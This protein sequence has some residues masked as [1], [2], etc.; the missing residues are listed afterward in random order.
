MLN[1][2]E[3]T[4]INVSSPKIDQVAEA[5]AAAVAEK[6]QQKA[7][8]L[9]QKERE[10]Q[11]IATGQTTYQFN[12]P[13]SQIGS[14]KD[15][16]EQVSPTVWRNRDGTF[17][18]KSQQGGTFNVDTEEGLK[19]AMRYDAASVKDQ[20]KFEAGGIA[21]TAVGTAETAVN[22][23]IDIGKQF[24]YSGA[25]GLE[26]YLNSYNMKNNDTAG[27]EFYDPTRNALDA[28]KVSQQYQQVLDTQKRS[29]PLTPEQVEFLAS[30][31]GKIAAEGYKEV[32]SNIK[33]L[34]AFD[35]AKVD[36]SAKRDGVLMDMGY[37]DAKERGG[38][39]EAIKYALNDPGYWAKAGVQSIPYMVALTAGGPVT[40]TLLVTSLARAKAA[41][42]TQEFWKENK[43]G[44]TAEEQ[45]Y[46]DAYS[47][48]STTAEKYADKFLLGQL[49]I[50]NK[51]LGNLTDLLPTS[52]QWLGG[53]G[54]GLAGEGASGAITETLDQLAVSREITDPTAIEFAAISEAFASPTGAAGVVVASSVTDSVIEQAKKERFTTGNIDS[55]IA[56]NNTALDKVAPAL[57]E[58][59]TTALQSQLEADKAEIESLKDQPS[60]KQRVDN[61]TRR[62]EQ[63][64]AKINTGRD[65]KFGANSSEVASEIQ[66]LLVR[67]RILEERKKNLNEPGLRAKLSNV[68][69]R[70]AD[71]VRPE[72]QQTE[73]V[74]TAVDSAAE[75]VP[76]STQGTPGPEASVVVDPKQE[77][78][79]PFI[80]A[81]SLVERLATL[82][83]GSTEAENLL[84]DI[85][86]HLNIA[87]NYAFGTEIAE[88]AKRPAI[89]RITAIANKV[90]E[91]AA[92]E[93]VDTKPEEDGFLNLSTP[94]DN[95][96]TDTKNSLDPDEVVQ[97][98]S[99][100]ESAA[101][102]QAYLSSINEGAQETGQDATAA[103]SQPASA[104]STTTVTENFLSNPEYREQQSTTRQ[105][106]PG[107]VQ[108]VEGIK[109]A[110]TV[111]KLNSRVKYLSN[112]A[113]RHVAK[114]QVYRNAQQAFTETKQPQVIYETGSG[115]TFA[116]ASAER[117]A[118]TVR[119]AFNV[120][121]SKG[122]ST[123]VAGIN[124]EATAAINAVERA[125]L[126]QPKRAAQLNR[127][128]AQALAQATGQ[129][130]PTQQDAAA[131]T[132]APPQTDRG[133]AATPAP[134][135]QSGAA[136]Q[137]SINAA[138]ETILAAVRSG[139]L[140]IEQATP[141]LAALAGSQAPATETTQT[142][143]T[144]AA[145]AVTV[146]D[147]AQEAPQT[148]DT[149]TPA[150]AETTAAPTQDEQATTPEETVVDTTPINTK[151]AF[152]TKYS[153]YIKEGT[154]ELVPFAE[155]PAE[156]LQEMAADIGACN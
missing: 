32:E 78:Y 18:F 106:R 111:S 40:N 120:T 133:V 53:K 6:A 48:V 2:D 116:A 130:V 134:A 95:V 65:L 7:E 70:A 103:T 127:R 67:N 89:D 19:Q 43:R 63:T 8:Q 72:T 155:L 66:P 45:F 15:A 44:P 90:N 42:N 148:T 35:D 86:Y 10:N 154:K 49:K 20:G 39:W 132:P 99:E 156:V 76:A 52:L 75:Y 125:R 33:T 124:Q 98:L 51:L 117:P 26:E 36:W 3:E 145:E 13:T 68:R 17:K 82:E 83:R 27:S 151:A 21:D 30:P 150:Q 24:A 118:G 73:A 121:N 144:A 97:P 92:P 143:T 1:P 152:I 113:E 5:K 108:I 23:G 122:I 139:E 11:Y 149:A 131:T 74:Q 47:A 58:E 128:S 123:T 140:T 153:Q 79:D 100:A 46:I 12:D 101:L 91:Y 87:G 142:A 61:L 141:A 136:S 28:Q 29:E 88:D 105:R 9:T 77:G 112:F 31:E 109:S 115:Y 37:R 96:S 146:A 25:T 137:S 59:Q 85:N 129:A 114:L 138:I 41:E 64:E 71:A 81:D 135:E 16:V 22:I 80:A 55:K 54:L 119:V 56:D 126:Y 104:S 84:G 93:E 107:L 110:N 4:E 57:S 69:Q 50:G 14:G 102:A 38:S 147:T 62:V 94:L 34:K 60:R